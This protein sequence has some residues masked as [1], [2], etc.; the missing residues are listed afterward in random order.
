MIYMMS[1][2]GARE[3]KVGRRRYRL[4]AVLFPCIRAFLSSVFASAVGLFVD[5]WL[6]QGNKRLKLR[7]TK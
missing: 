6:G 5:L 2:D 3:P 4:C 1:K 7:E